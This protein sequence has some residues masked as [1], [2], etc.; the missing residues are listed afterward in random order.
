MIL[1]FTLP[2]GDMDNV[3]RFFMIFWKKPPDL[4]A[5]IGWRA[6]GTNNKGDLVCG[7]ISFIFWPLPLLLMCVWSY[8][9]H[10]SISPCSVGLFYRKP[11]RLSVFCKLDIW[12]R[13]DLKPQIC[14]GGFSVT[15]FESNVLKSSFRTS[16]YFGNVLID[17][18][19]WSKI[20][21]E[22]LTSFR[23]VTLISPNPV[24]P[25]LDCWTFSLHSIDCRQWSWH[26]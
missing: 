1:W 15:V 17:Q 23:L 20:I 25:T 6:Q 8:Q 11:Y 12:K 19:L 9:Y 13:F 10:V 26:R 16:T 3:Q 24:C 21:W 18:V 14:Y 2:T 4:Y 5:K 7:G 22:M